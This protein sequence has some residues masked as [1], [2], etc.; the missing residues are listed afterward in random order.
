MRRLVGSSAWSISPLKAAHG[1]C[2]PAVFIVSCNARRYSEKHHD[3][4]QTTTTEIIN[5]LRKDDF[6]DIQSKFQW[7]LGWILSEQRLRKLWKIPT[8]VFGSIV[9][10]SVPQVERK[11]TISTTKTL[12]QFQRCKFG[13]KV[14]LSPS[15]KILGLKFHPPT[16][17]GLTSEWVPPQ[18]VTDFSSAEADTSVRTGVWPP[19]KG[20]L[21]IPTK[22]GPYSAVLF[23]SGSGNND[24]DLSIG[25]IRPAKD[26]AWGLASKGIAV[27]RL[28]KPKLKL[29]YK[30]FVTKDITM[31]DEYMPHN[32]AGIRLLA[33][34]PD[35]D[36]SQI[37]VI[38][39]SL[40]GRIAPRLCSRS[41]IPIAGMISMAGSSRSLV[42]TGLY[43]MKWFQK[44][45]PRDEADFKNELAT[46]EEL[47]RILETPDCNPRSPNPTK[48]LPGTIPLSY[49]L[50]DKNTDPVELAKGLKIPMLFLQGDKDFQ[51]TVDDDFRRWR[52][53]LE[54]AEAQGR[55]TFKLYEGLNHPFIRY[56]GQEKGLKQYDEPGHVEEEVVNDIAKWIHG[57]QDHAKELGKPSIMVQDSHL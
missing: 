56:T 43:Q 31:E 6:R 12:V 1:G 48:G 33:D 36:P 7:P 39:L 55:A 23:L 35:V 26:L 5:S 29:A 25:A 41:P 44:H 57:P 20:S 21:T 42:D 49:L 32:L 45:F 15:H 47:G 3:D 16:A 28:D 11:G 51:V 46:M 13:L 54:S 27:L 14:T 8:Q 9:D 24:R 37:Y 50:E 38:G 18:Y 22:P 10:F 40:G 53:G 30:I 4:L 19:V 17:I 52:E 34:Y 2:K